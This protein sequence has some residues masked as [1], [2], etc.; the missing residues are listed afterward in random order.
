MWPFPTRG[1]CFMGDIRERFPSALQ[2]EDFQRNVAVIKLWLP[3]KLLAGIDVLCEVHAASR[4]DILRWIFFEHAFGRT[5]LS[6][7]QRWAEAHRG[8]G[9][10]LSP[11]RRIAGSSERYENRETSGSINARFLGKAT[12]DL[13]LYLP[14][15]L[16]NELVA[17]AEQQAQRVSDYLRGVLARQLLGERLFQEWQQALTQANTQAR[18][19]ESEERLLSAT[20]EIEHRPSCWDYHTG[21]FPRA[22]DPSPEP[23]P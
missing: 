3:E 9:P 18:T 1:S 6:L 8:E 14:E 15:A 17:L 16:R 22:E 2:G 20:N 4:P 5:E 7:L 10:V 13:K 12:E 19:N 23:A 11:A 21:I